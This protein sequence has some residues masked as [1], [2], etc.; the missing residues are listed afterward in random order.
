MAEGDGGGSNPSWEPWLSSFPRERWSHGRVGGSSVVVE[1]FYC[2]THI[3][4]H[5][6]DSIVEHIISIFYDYESSSVHT[7]RISFCFCVS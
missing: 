4:E 1:K 6:L 5:I 7:R 3:I 2:R